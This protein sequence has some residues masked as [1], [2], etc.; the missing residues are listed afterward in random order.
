MVQALVQAET[1]WVTYCQ[2]FAA[3]MLL[4][5]DDR[6][7]V[8]GWELHRNEGQGSWEAYVVEASVGVPGVYFAVAIEVP[9]VLTAQHR[10]LARYCWRTA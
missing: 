6:E 7:K 9:V 2:L 4:Q 8:A 10:Q 3:H 1:C 5:E